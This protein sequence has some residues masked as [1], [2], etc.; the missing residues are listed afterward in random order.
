[1]SMLTRL[2]TY[3]PQKK[4]WVLTVAYD[5]IIGVN[6]T[7]ETMVYRGNEREITNYDELDF[8]DLGCFP[9]EEYLKERHQL[10]VQKWG[11]KT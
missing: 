2:K 4:L 5:T 8:E 3:V 10:M 6:R 11:M 9:P 7:A 1:M